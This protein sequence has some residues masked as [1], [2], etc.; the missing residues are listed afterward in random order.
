MSNTFRCHHH[1]CCF[2]KD[3]ITKI[4]CSTTVV[5]SPASPKHSPG[6]EHKKYRNQDL[7]KDMGKMVSERDRRGYKERINI[8]ILT[9]NTSHIMFD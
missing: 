9:K 1:P 7:V 2:S 5:A 3:Q 6:Y 4:I 8:C